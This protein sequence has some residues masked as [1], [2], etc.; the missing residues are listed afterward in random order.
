MN[1]PATVIE[2]RWHRWRLLRNRRG[3]RAGLILVTI[4]P[5]YRLSELEFALAKV[6][7]SAIVAATAFK[8]TRIVEDRRSPTGTA[9]PR[10]ALGRMGDTANLGRQHDDPGSGD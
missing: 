10:S 2:E 6:G 4:N 8:R 3:L 1:A 9:G 7:C 5:A